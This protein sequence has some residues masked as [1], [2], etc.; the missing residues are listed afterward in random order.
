MRHG[1]AADLGF[2]RDHGHRRGAVADAMQ[3]GDR[4]GYELGLRISA[5][6]R[7]WPPHAR[8]CGNRGGLGER[9]L[10]DLSGVDFLDQKNI[11]LFEVRL[12]NR[13]SLFGL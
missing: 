2:I 5:A 6:L 1:A 11:S 13:H 9:R 3:T 10:G 4:S 8:L 12:L 7:L